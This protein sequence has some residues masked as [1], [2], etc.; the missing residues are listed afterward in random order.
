MTEKQTMTPADEELDLDHALVAEVAELVDQGDRGGI[1]NI[2]ED[3]HA[4]DIADL[5]EQLPATQRV[6]LVEMV[7]PDLDPEA[8]SE[9]EEGVRDEV[10]E[11]MDPAHLAAAVKELDSDDV[12][13]LVEDLDKEQQEKVLSALEGVD[14]IAVEQSLLYPENTAGRLMQRE[15]VTAPQFFDVGNVIDAMRAATDLPSNFYSII[16]VDPKFHPIG[17]VPLSRLMASRRE[18][19]LVDIMDEDF[20]TFTAD[21]AQEEVARTFNKYHLISAPITD[22]DGRLVGVI[23]IDDAMEVLAEAAEED[24]HR[25]GGVGDEE[26]SDKFWEIA[27]RRLPWLIINLLT[28]ILSASV[29]AFFGGTIEQIV[30]LA[31]LMPI[32][33]SMG[34]NA[35]TQGLTVAVRAL[36]T[37]SITRANARRVILR[38]GLVGLS[39]GLILAGLIGVAAGLWFADWWLGGVLAMA[40]LLTLL[41]AGLAGILIPLGMAR[42]GVDPAVAS[43]VFLTTVTDV[44]GFFTFLGLA[45]L[46]L[47]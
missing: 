38:E 46:F 13:Y 35:G 41:V 4:A 15:L 39:N 12:V 6:A 45:T 3:L 5:I 26:L 44:V 37:K 36:A 7:G 43:S 21:T 42:A 24:M 14:R 31:A 30:A 22:A 33:A 10:I 32:V 18:V 20:T 34:G 40:M 47:I 17:T 28:A 16:V 29:V 19:K 23:T 8:L 25:M 2:L 11:A 1:V 27:L 9:L